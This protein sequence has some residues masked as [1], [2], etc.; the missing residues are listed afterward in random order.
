MNTTID[1]IQILPMSEEGFDKGEGDLHSIQ[2]NYLL[3]ELPFEENVRYLI[4]GKRGIAKPKCT[5]ILFKYK[6]AIIGSGILVDKNIKE[7][8]L[9]FLPSSLKIYLSPI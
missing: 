6:T 4:V 8:Y 2:F 7:K 1:K 5:F 3:R 9:Q